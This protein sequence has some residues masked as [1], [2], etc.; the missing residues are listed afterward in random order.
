MERLEKVS[1]PTPARVFDAV[2]D[3]GAIIRVRQHGNPAGPRLVL[4]HGNGLAI[5][6]YLSFWG[7]LCNSHEVI[8]FDIRNHGENPLHG[9][10]AH[11]HLA[12]FARDLETVCAA[13]ERELGARPM[14]GVFHSLS[15]LAAIRHAETHPERWRA[16]VLFDPPIYPRDGHP[17]R[18][19]QHASKESL[20]SRA[21]RRTGR[22]AHPN[23]FA[24]QLASIP[25]FKR[26]RREAYKLMA[27][28]TLKPEGSTGTWVLRCPR[29]FEAQVFDESRDQ[30]LWYGVGRLKVPVKL[31]CG[32]PNLEDAD[33]PALIGQA[34][35][36]EFPIAY[37]A[38]PDSTHFLQIERPEECIRAMESF[39]AKHGLAA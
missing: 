9:D 1:L 8:L 31:V 10:P 18:T 13:V 23:D 25:A 37:E 27:Y 14:A 24:A 32:D 35:A 26:W 2:M 15:A 17:L 20:A 21:R 5:D 28:A 36:R 3:D 6:A 34:I 30:E 16:L 7:P 38:I 29:E 19:E 11:H 33:A 12:Q 22:Y 39:L 4:S